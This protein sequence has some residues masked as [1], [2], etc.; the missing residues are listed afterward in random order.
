MVVDTTYYDLLGVS[1]N[2]RPIEIKKAYRKKSVQE[3]PDK[4]PNDPSATERFQSISQAYQV[5]SN[6]ELRTKYDKFGKE[7]AVPQNGFEDAAEQFSAIFG[8]DAFASYVGELTLLKNLQ[9]TEELSAED[10]AEKKQQEK[11]ED[12]PEKGSDVQGKGD[13]N[14]SQQSTTEPSSNVKTLPSTHANSSEVNDKTK[15]GKNE[16]TKKSKLEQ[17][18]EEQR[19]EKDKSIEELSKTLIDRLSILT[20]SVYDNACKESFQKKFE[21]EANI[22]KMESFGLDILHT[23]GE[24]YCEKAQIFLK[25]QHLS[26]IH[27]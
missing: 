4:N 16:K 18:E 17:F 1:P 23:I 10:E 21:E 12:V 13:G 6:E 25:G 15:D 14:T 3:H 19:K 20:E 27:I 24:V 2:A 5:L 9:K 11:G 7:E 8:G 22:L 26:L